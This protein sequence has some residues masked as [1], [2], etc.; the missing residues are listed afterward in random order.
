MSN[1]I[2]IR[3]N[4]DD[5]NSIGAINNL[6]G[7]INN[8]SI[9][10]G[11]A[12]RSVDNMNKSF[13]VLGYTM[14]SVIRHAVGITAAFAGMRTIEG[15]VAHARENLVGFD[16]AMKES[17]AFSEHNRFQV[18]KWGKEIR[19]IAR[20]MPVSAREMAESLR[21]V[22]SAGL[23]A[24]QVM[25]V[26]ELSSRG[27]AAGMGEAKDVG[28]AVASV[29]NAYGAENMNAS[30][31]LDILTSAVKSGMGDMKDYATTLD[32]VLPLASQLGISFEEVAGSLA[33]MSN[34]GMSLSEGTTAFRQMASNIIKM[35]KEAREELLTLGMTPGDVVDM[36][37]ES[38]LADTLIHLM[39]LAGGDTEII[40]K[41]FPNIRGLT[42][43]LATASRQTE[44]YKQAVDDA[45]NSQGEF[46]R[47]TE[48]AF[49]SVDANMKIFMNNVTEVGLG[50]GE[51]LLPHVVSISQKLSADLGP[52]IEG[53]GEQA[54][55]S[56][57]RFSELGKTLKPISDFI[58]DM[59]TEST[60][61]NL[62][63]TLKESLEH[64]VE[65]IKQ[66]SKE[67]EVVMAIAGLV[68]ASKLTGGIKG[69]IGTTIVPTIAGSALHQHNVASAKGEL[70]SASSLGL[71]INDYRRMQENE[72]MGGINYTE[73]L[74]QQTITQRKQYLADI[75]KQFASQSAAEAA[76]AEDKVSQ[77]YQERLQF[78]R[79][80]IDHGMKNIEQ[81]IQD[82]TSGTGSAMQKNISQMWSDAL[83]GA[84]FDAIIGKAG[85]DMRTAI[86]TYF[87]A[88][89]A[90]V[91][92]GLQKIAIIGTDIKMAWS[93][94]LKPGD[95]N[96]V[97]GGLDAAQNALVAGSENSDPE[98]QAALQKNV[99]DAIASG[100]RLIIRRN[101]EEQA[102]RDEEQAR[103]KAEAEA[104][105]ARNVAIV[106]LRESLAQER[107]EYNNS[108]SN[109]GGGALAAL[110]RSFEDNTADAG[111]AISRE[112][113]KIA[114][115]MREENIPEWKAMWD[116]LVDT[117]I[118]A[119]AEKT[120]EAL[121]AAEALAAQIEGVFTER[122]TLTPER[123]MEDFRKTATGQRT[124]PAGAQILRNLESKN[125]P[126][127]VIAAGEMTPEI[128]QSLTGGT[129]KLFEDFREAF[130][131]EG[132]RSRMNMVLD[133]INDVIVE[134]TPDSLEG[135][136]SLLE[137]MNWDTLAQ[138]IHE[139]YDK[140]LTEA[141][142]RFAEG[143]KNLRQKM[144]DR[145]FD[146]P[147][148]NRRIR[149]ELDLSHV[150]D[151]EERENLRNSLMLDEGNTSARARR[152]DLKEAER[153]AI[154]IAKY[155]RDVDEDDP[156]VKHEEMH[157]KKV[158]GRALEDDQVKRER[159]REDLVNQQKKALD[160]MLRP[161]IAL[162]KYNKMSEEEKKAAIEKLNEQ[163][164]EQSLRQQFE[165]Q[166]RAQKRK[167][168][169]E[170]R[171]RKRK[172]QDEEFDREIAKEIKIAQIQAEFK[173]KTKQLEEQI[174]FEE[175]EEQFKNMK[176]A[177]TEAS[178]QALETWTK[179]IA[180]LTPIF[181]ELLDGMND[182]W[183]YA[184]ERAKEIA[185]ITSGISLSEEGVELT[186]KAERPKNRTYDDIFNSVDRSGFEPDEGDN[187]TTYG[188]KKKKGNDIDP[189]QLLN[190][191]V[192]Y[193]MRASGSG[194]SG[195]QYTGVAQQ[196][197]TDMTTGKV[198][199]NWN[200]ASVYGNLPGY[201][202]PGSRLE[203][204]DASAI[205]SKGG[206]MIRNEIHI[207][208][209]LVGGQAGL[210]EF[211]RILADQMRDEMLSVLKSG[212]G[213]S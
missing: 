198:M 15:T 114:D 36:I 191:Y 161:G 115:K 150:E 23:P 20:T 89:G 155:G 65:F 206:V 1:D 28:L 139:A 58:N 93:R 18:E 19:E 91:E 189:G 196:G 69:G 62:I 92:L 11:S 121:A 7:A 110:V 201:R 75:E 194:T 211:A 123:F 63:D 94:A 203:D 12:S 106:G 171:Q 207:H 51:R 16:K 104:R 87:D 47:A 122:K 103:R 208:G 130:D 79:D 105:A 129:N 70:D 159:E 48:I 102:A 96:V 27:A 186:D 55:E 166:Q 31:A 133:A 200:P 9:R 99:I 86:E 188:I 182:D 168:E 170:D 153:R 202:P 77:D 52:A 5:K 81:Y 40:T 85:V 35:G 157:D 148:F 167:W 98:T 26:L 141:N 185:E 34:I 112:L 192:P 212:G 72:A 134:R 205:G 60:G 118:T 195:H 57:D 56:K 3:I 137:Q 164:R 190:G 33:T 213:T 90:A 145:V 25:E 74:P 17:A 83:A 64:L 59:N 2:N 132:A 135:L 119:T 108:F 154:A 158:R 109:I 66:N 111:K 80:S 146:I 84:E 113:I 184:K 136:R 183:D 151:D 21:M 53:A 126:G 6:G 107:A 42:G 173:L 163:N 149:E 160:N 24:S 143:M 179:A 156:R 142:K 10:A 193:A 165:E 131:P 61:K 197:V 95:F 22:G 181:D 175:Y 210:R 97:A 128:L 204:V 43:L 41:I 8:L 76:R 14:N 127:D 67:F 138:P 13:H 71:N 30:K 209:P 152:K 50:L 124:G 46:A 29:I 172:E 32:K 178:K 176:D 177:H 169:D 116:E 44:A 82:E 117:F 140:A 100:Q 39:D 49:E 120:P 144:E 147:G 37:K 162:D 180:K 125:S 45:K 73:G 4:I 54:D 78:V 174:S 38:G 199:S 101:Q 187:L 68:G 88:S